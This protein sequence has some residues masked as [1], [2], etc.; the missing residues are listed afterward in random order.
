MSWGSSKAEKKGSHGSTSLCKETEAL[1]DEAMKKRGLS[2]RAAKE[3]KESIAS[4]GSDPFLIFSSRTAQTSKALTSKAATNGIPK[5]APP[6]ALQAS[7]SP[8]ARFSNI[9][10]REDIERLHGPVSE[11]RDTF[12]PLP[13]V[14]SRDHQKDVL[15]NIMLHG[16]ARKAR[17]AQIL[18]A[19]RR[20]EAALKKEEEERQLLDPKEALISQIFQEITERRE[21]LEELVSRGLA[22]SSNQKVAQI[23]GEIASRM[24]ELAKLGFDTRA[25][26]PKNIRKVQDPSSLRLI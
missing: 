4:G 16:D 6:S 1:L 2:I 23:K 24:A 20:E 22:T 9:R 19:R 17:E 5:P 10:L 18:D 12:K 11:H 25:G 8:P 13:P 26:R 3:M 21:H 7:G 15:S 14:P